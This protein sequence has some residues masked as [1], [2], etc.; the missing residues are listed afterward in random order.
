[1]ANWRQRDINFSFISS[2]SVLRPH[3]SHLL[4]IF[5]LFIPCRMTGWMVGW[6]GLG[7]WMV[8]VPW[9]SS[10]VVAASLLLPTLPTFFHLLFCATTWLSDWL[11]CLLTDCLTAVALHCPGLIGPQ[12]EQ[13]LASEKVIIENKYYISA[14]LCTVY[15]SPVFANKLNIFVTKFHSVVCVVSCGVGSAV[16]CCSI[17]VDSCGKKRQSGENWTKFYPLIISTLVSIDDHFSFS[18]WPSDSQISRH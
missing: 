15:L 18:L 17:T 2:C 8:R 11:A 3:L 6:L 4:L 10:V 1:M 5:S 9:V 14:Q 7:E 12:W 13:Q 16:L